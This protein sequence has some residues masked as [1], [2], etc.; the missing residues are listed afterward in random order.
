MQNE[1]KSCKRP[2][3]SIRIKGASALKDPARLKRFSLWET[4]LLDVA[5]KEKSLLIKRLSK[6]SN[7]LR[8]ELLSIEDNTN[9]IKHF[10]KKISF[11]L[12]QNTTKWKEWPNKFVKKSK[13]V[14]VLDEI[15]TMSE[16]ADLR[17]HN[18]HLIMSSKSFRLL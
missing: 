18:H 12:I 16:V 13:S 2:P 4:E 14:K 8:E 1:S 11:Y 10:Q 9:I 3:P 17:K 5:I 6:K 15:M 7:N